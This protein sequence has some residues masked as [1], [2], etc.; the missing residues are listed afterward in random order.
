MDDIGKKIKKI[1]KEMGMKQKDI[2]RDLEVSQSYISEVE[3]GKE[4][5]TKRFI[6]LFCLQYGISE[7]ELM[8][9]NKSPESE[10]AG[11]EIEQLGSIIEASDHMEEKKIWLFDLAHGN[12]ERDAIV[13]GFIRF[14]ILQ[15]KTVFN[16]QYDVHFHTIYGDDN[17]RRAMEDLK[18]AL[19]A[20]AS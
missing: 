15:G 10:L 14:Y 3:N 11:L 2:S 13:K 12:L 7:D 16:V 19:E 6:K 8:V 20:Y 17:C 18:S 5:P 1:R 9:G 4:I